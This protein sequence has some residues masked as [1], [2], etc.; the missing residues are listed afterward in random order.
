M[1]I[2]KLSAQ[3]YVRETINKGSIFREDIT[4]NENRDIYYI[5]DSFENV[6][7]CA[8]KDEDIQNILSITKVADF[9]IN[10]N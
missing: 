10:T 5:S 9:F 7:E 3:V 2:F 4:S 8:K 1:K 6:I